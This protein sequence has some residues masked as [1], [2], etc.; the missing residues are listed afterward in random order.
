[1]LERMGYR[2][3]VGANGAEALQALHRQFYDAVFMDI[4]MPIMD[5]MEATRRIRQ[6]FSLASQPRI[7]AMTANAMSGDREACL[8]AGMD[9]Y[10][11]KPI[12]IAEL[13]NCLNRCQP[14][15]VRDQ[16]LAGDY[17]L[18]E[19]AENAAQQASAG[20]LPGAEMLVIDT[21][22]LVK[23]RENLGP[24]SEVLLPALIASYCK[25]AEKL[26]EEAREA[27]DQA[28]PDDLRRSAHTLK[29]NSAAFGAKRLEAAARLLEEEARQEHLNLAGELI[30]QV[31]AEFGLVRGALHEAQQLV[32]HG[33]QKLET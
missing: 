1:M 21:T 27:Y 23:L 12:H 31:E 11:S 17:R 19:H 6:E 3:D 24:K 10:I 7:I 33:S 20:L 9:D 4:Q 18:E 16:A 8:Q 13:V 29:S 26:I 32:L 15:N 30:N 14:R 25:Q 22:E 2:A 28:H 5:G